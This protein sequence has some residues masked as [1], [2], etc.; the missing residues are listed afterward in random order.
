MA[1]DAV[2]RVVIEHESGVQ[3]NLNSTAA[4]IKRFNYDQAYANGVLN[5]YYSLYLQGVVS[6]EEDQQASE[7]ETSLFEKARA[8]TSGQRRNFGVADEEI[9]MRLV[10]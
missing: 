4:E 9:L 7:E 2:I 8:A 1:Q 10:S 3:Y 5:K 6:A